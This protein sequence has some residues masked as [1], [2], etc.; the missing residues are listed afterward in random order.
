[1]LPSGSVGVLPPG[2]NQVCVALGDFNFRAIC[3][4]AG[5]P[6]S[7]GSAQRLLESGEFER[8]TDF[9]ERHKQLR[10][11][12]SSESSASA[13]TA[14]P[15]SRGLETCEVTLPHF[16]EAYIRFPPTY[17]YK[18]HSNAYDGKRHPAWCDR[19]LW[20]SGPRGADGPEE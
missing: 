19:V 16:R 17:K 15:G 20:H 9:D 14:S 12:T 11:A 13:S 5:M 18:R 10:S 7:K 3:D 4:A 8:Y 1:M 2:P 6:L